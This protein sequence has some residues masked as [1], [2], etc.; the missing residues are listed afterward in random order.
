MST[1]PRFLVAAIAVAALALPASA[2][3]RAKTSYYVALGDSY[4]QGYQPIGPNQADVITDKGFN[5]YAFKKLR[6]SH[7]GLKLVKLGCGGGPT[8]STIN[9]RRPRGKKNPHARPPRETSQ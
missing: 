3:A 4:A 8:H 7:H 6:R 1:S 2:A 5:D 9:G